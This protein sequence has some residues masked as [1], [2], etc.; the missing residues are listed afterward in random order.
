MLLLFTRSSRLRKY[1]PQ[2]LE[3]IVAT[4]AGFHTDSDGIAAE[5]IKMSA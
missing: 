1:I 3:A 2:S 4:D 5:S